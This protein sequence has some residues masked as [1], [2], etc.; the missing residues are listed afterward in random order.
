MPPS[1]LRRGEPGATARQDL[2]VLFDVADTLL[3][4]ADLFAAIHA[5]LVRA[6]YDREESEIRV[7]QMRL[8]ERT[9]F[10][11]TAGWKFYEGFNSALLQALGLPP[12]FDLA[13]DI[14]RSCRSLPWRAF[15]DVSAL[16]TLPANIG[17]VTNWDRQLRALLSR[18]VGLA[19]EPIVVSSEEGVA[20][21]DPAIFTTAL[22]RVGRVRQPVFYVGDSPRLD[23][24]PA[25]RAGLRPILIDRFDLYD[26]LAGL[27]IRSLADLAEL[28]S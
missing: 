18:L 14:Y 19:F 20:K 16:S 26:D 17:V 1:N 2:T 28:V 10:P 6:G 25:A 9:Q 5:C 15:D 7:V 13:L 11:D 24:A 12:A 22:A 23:I 27:R 4:K 8:K 3:Y 21:P